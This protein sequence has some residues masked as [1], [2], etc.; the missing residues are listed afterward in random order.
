MDSDYDYSEKSVMPT[1]STPDHSVQ[2]AP[3]AATE[4]IT[5]DGGISRS[6]SLKANAPHTLAAGVTRSSSMRVTRNEMRQEQ[7]R[8]SDNPFDDLEDESK[9][10][11]RRAVS[12][13]K[14]QRYPKNKLQSADITDKRP[15]SEVLSHPERESVISIYS[16][17][18]AIQVMRAKPMVVRVD[19]LKGR[20][21]RITRKTSQRALPS[22]KSESQDASA[23]ED[24]PT[25]H[26]KPSSDRNSKSLSTVS[27]QS[28]SSQNMDGEITIF[29]DNN[30][31][32]SNSPAESPTEGAAHSKSDISEGVNQ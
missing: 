19:S 21:G 23:T 30:G 6:L 29:W 5:K 12:V 20:D 22:S 13:K 16:A 28:R 32:P 15:K 18:P 4:M 1:V 25:S 27:A 31:K 11:L 7:K 9:V 3:V 17:T 14:S 10:V 8:L 26:L 24:N 2:S